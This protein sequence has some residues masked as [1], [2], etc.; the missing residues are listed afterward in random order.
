MTFL[1][2]NSIKMLIVA[3]LLIL[4]CVFI[5]LDL[6]HYLTFEYLKN[7]RAQFLQYHQEHPLLTL[8]SFF[9]SYVLMA[10]ISLPGG[11]IMALAAGAL[12]GLV[13]GTIVV[14]FASTIGATLAMLVSRLLLGAYVQTKFKDQLTSIN[15]KIEEEGAYYLFTMRLIPAF[16]FF[17]TNLVMGLVPIR[18][19]TFYW[20]SQTGMLAG[21]LVFVNAGSELIKI[22]SFKDMASP[23]LWLSFALLGIFPL[24]VKKIM[25]Y[26][27]R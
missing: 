6:Q 13:T 17:M 26:V 3:T 25:V 18:V 20:V 5:A 27:R 1:K 15:R 16:P 7:S 23:G 19:F 8:G 11:T 9:I 12:F 10:A 2:K 4:V 14:S 21:T 22:D 24:I